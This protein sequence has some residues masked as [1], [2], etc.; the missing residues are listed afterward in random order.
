MRQLLIECSDPGLV[1]AL[2]EEMEHVLRNVDFEWAQALQ[3]QLAELARELGQDFEE[4]WSGFHLEV[5]GDGHDFPPSFGNRNTVDEK[6]LQELVTQAEEKGIGRFKTRLSLLLPHGGPTPETRDQFIHDLAD[7]IRLSLWHEVQYPLHRLTF[8]ESMEK[9]RLQLLEEH[10]GPAL[11]SSAQEPVLG[12]TWVQESM[13]CVRKAIEEVDTRAQAVMEYELSRLDP[14]QVEFE[15]KAHWAVLACC[16]GKE[17]EKWYT[18]SANQLPYFYQRAALIAELWT[19]CRGVG[20]ARQF[21]QKRFQ[22]LIE[23]SASVYTDDGRQALTRVLDGLRRRPWDQWSGL[24][25]EKEDDDSEDIISGP[26]SGR[27]NV[28]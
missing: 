8:P 16:A 17:V 26:K 10:V 21:L 23:E 13:E 3:A 4:V 6:K 20:P 14:D 18:A 24:V 25:G 12:Y 1:V 19:S 15:E 28:D 7:A 27:L 2:D 22:E 11:R 5:A 9:H